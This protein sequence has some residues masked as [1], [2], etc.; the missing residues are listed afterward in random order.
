MEENMKQQFYAKIENVGSRG[1]ASGGVVGVRVSLMHK[2]GK[3]SRVVKGPVKEG[4]I[5]ALMECERE[6]RRIR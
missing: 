6:E 3:L 1:G 2:N 4:D 5:I